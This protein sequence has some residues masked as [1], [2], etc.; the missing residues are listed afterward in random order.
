MMKNMNRRKFLGDTVKGAAVVTAAGALTSFSMVPGMERKAKMPVRV[1]G[2]TG[3]EVSILSFG[4]GSQFLKNGDGTWE[5]MLQE[6]VKSGINL[7][8][9]SPNYSDFKTS[10]D[11]VGPDERFARILSPVRDKVLISTK[12]E[13][14][15]PKEVREELEAS[16][17]RLN[18]DYVDI[19]MIHA[20]NDQDDI[21]EIEK[22]IYKEMQDIKK[23][24]IAQIY[25][26]LKHVQR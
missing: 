18:T 24:G 12:V 7:Y 4:G 14:R 5:K 25:R 3:L 26:I 6:A 1:L 22:G 8:D 16:L 20:L 2:K 15:N 19:L 10:E 17:S 9:T 13:T 23:A 11:A 21:G